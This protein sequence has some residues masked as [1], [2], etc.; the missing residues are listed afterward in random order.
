LTR[1]VLA[2]EL[3]IDP[4]QPLQ[5]LELAILNQAPDL[6][7]PTRLEEDTRPGRPFGTVTF[8]FSEI[9]DAIGLWERVPETMAAAVRRHDELM[10]SAL[11][12]TGGYVF[13]TAGNAFWAVFDSAKDAI[14]AAV[15]AQ[16]ALQ[17]QPWPDAAGN[18]RQVQTDC[19]VPR[20]GA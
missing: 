19:A 12:L 9:E 14:E 18:P 15:R 7:G 1:R 20:C 5:S 16:R 8:V 13:R 6:A 2:E 17:S 10:G 3:C 4:S 11:E